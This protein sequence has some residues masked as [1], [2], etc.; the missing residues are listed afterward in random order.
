VRKT[1]VEIKNEDEVIEIKYKGKTIL[2]MTVEG[3]DLLLDE[4]SEILG[5]VKGSAARKEIKDRLNRV[6]TQNI[7]DSFWNS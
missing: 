7:P 4:K 2:L 6:D 1:T 3:E 5:I